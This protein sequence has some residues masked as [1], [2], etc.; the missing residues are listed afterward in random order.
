M[1]PGACLAPS[2]PLQRRRRE[3][4]PTMITLAR[5]RHLDRPLVRPGS[6][7]PPKEQTQVL[8]RPFA[9]SSELVHEFRQAPLAQKQH[10]LPA[11]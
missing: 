11:L 5:H 9:A 2:S 4:E 10:P 3:V 8:G 7:H 6:G 1:S